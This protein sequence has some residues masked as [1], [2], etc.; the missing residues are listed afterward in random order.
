MLF[1]DTAQRYD[2]ANLAG[3]LGHVGVRVYFGTGPDWPEAVAPAAFPAQLAQAV[4]GGIAPE[5][6]LRRATRDALAW[7][8]VEKKL[9]GLSPGE[10]AD[11]VVWSAHPLAGDAR[12]EQVYIAGQ[13][14]YGAE[15]AKDAK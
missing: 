3:W 13:R 15:L 10:P 2:P 6:P 1:N 9:G 14:V 12:V 8:G 4:A 5:V 11:F 7:L